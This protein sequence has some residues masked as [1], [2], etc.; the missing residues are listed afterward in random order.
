M[1]Q[2]YKIKPLSKLKKVTF[3]YNIFTKYHPNI[4]NKK[5]QNY[6]KE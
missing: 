4:E 6:L 3:E 5:K 2:K 1:E